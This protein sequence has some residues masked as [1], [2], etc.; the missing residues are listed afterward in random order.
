MNSLLLKAL[1]NIPE[2]N[3]GTDIADVIF[4]NIQAENISVKNGDIF[5]IAQ[6]IISK[7]ENRYIKLE[8]I[9][10]SN[11]ALS[12]AK[13]V[14][15]TAEFIQVILDESNK[16]LS[17]NNDILLTEHRLGFTNINAGIDISNIK[18]NKNQV[19]LLPEDPNKSAI[20]LGTKISNLLNVN[21]EIIISDSMTR[22]QRYGITGFAIGSSN[23]NC[24]LDKKGFK[25]MYNNELLTTEIAIGDE[26]AAAASIL[27]GQCDERQPIV[28]ISGYKDA[29]EFKTN[30]KS[31]GI[32]KKDDIYGY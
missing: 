25:D 6:K 13:K 21:I 17:S 29:T 31:L 2:I 7:A 27:M 12:L 14:N 16:I 19:L 30:A 24:L 32:L 15:K 28:L 5:V 1:V 3:P 20:D 10:P 22:P 18:D 23:I 11:E 4:N 8:N 9:E 26:L